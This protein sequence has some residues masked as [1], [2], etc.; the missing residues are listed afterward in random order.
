MVGKYELKNVCN[1]QVFCNR[2]DIEKD[3]N[4]FCSY[5]YRE[6][7]KLSDQFFNL[8]CYP[9]D[10]LKSKMIK[11]VREMIKI[12]FSMFIKEHTPDLKSLKKVFWHMKRLSYHFEVIHS[13]VDQF[14][15]I[16]NF[17]ILLESYVTSYRIILEKLHQ[18]FPEE[19]L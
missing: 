2:E 9:A 17:P 18:F 7:E 3:Y 10:Q 5:E 4:I 11:K 15:S 13:Y 16:S 14:D 1:V 19:S 8:S 12:S 6:L